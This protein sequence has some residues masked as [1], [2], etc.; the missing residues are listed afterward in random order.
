MEG[1][2]PVFEAIGPYATAMPWQNLARQSNWAE[3]FHQARA[4]ALDQQPASR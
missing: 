2:G 4:Y 3:D 1:A